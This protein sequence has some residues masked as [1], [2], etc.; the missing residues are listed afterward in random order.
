MALYLFSTHFF[1]FHSHVKSF[2]S[3]GVIADIFCYGHKD[4]MVV[5]DCFILR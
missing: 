4:G 2:P 3:G 5:E 1:L